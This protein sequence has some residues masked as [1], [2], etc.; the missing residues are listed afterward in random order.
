MM[1]GGDRLALCCPKTEKVANFL[2]EIGLQVVQVESASGFVDHVEIVHG[3]IHLDEHAAVSD[4]LHEAGHVAIMPQRYRSY[5]NGNIGPGVKRM[6]EELTAL[7]LPTDDPLYRAA[8]QT[9]DCE[10]T[11]WAWA[12]GKH[13]GLNDDEIIRD[14]DYN[15]GGEHVRLGLAFRGYLGINGL[16]HAGFCTVRPNP[17]RA[18]IPVYPE[19]ARWLQA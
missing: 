2:R 11:A 3:A 12:A 15:G 10:A 16:A 8:I 5:L 14:E 13:L 7:H 9:S 4:L 18:G 17:Y 6:L 1:K 19:L